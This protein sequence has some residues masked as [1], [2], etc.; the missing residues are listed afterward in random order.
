MLRQL[1]AFRK[2]HGY[3]RVDEHWKRYPELAGWIVAIRGQLETLTYDQIVSLND[4]G[5]FNRLDREWLAKYARLQ[6]FKDTMGHCDVPARW[7]KN[8]ALSVWVHN[9]RGKVQIVPWRRKLLSDLGFNFRLVDKSPPI[10][11]DDGIKRLKQYKER[12]GNCDV[13]ARWSEDK[14]LG[15]WLSRLRKRDVKRSLGDEK[16]RQLDNLGFAWNPFR[17]AW[18]LKLRELRAFKEQHGHCRVPGSPDGLGCWVSNIRHT[19]EKL[20]ETRIRRLNEIG[21]DWNPFQT[22]WS[23]QYKNILDYKQRFGHANVPAHWK[24]NPEL[25]RWVSEQR[26]KKAELS[27]DRIQLLEDAGIDWD[28]NETAWVRHYEELKE[29]RKEHGHCN[30]PMS[31]SLLRKWVDHQRAKADKMP[32][33]RKKLLDELGF[34]WTGYNQKVWMQRYEELK[35]YKVKHGHCSPPAR[36]SPLAKW[37]SV[38]RIMK[39]KMLTERRQLLDEIGFEWQILPHI[40]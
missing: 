18:E 38:Q 37:V 30:P 29:F 31:Q 13:P 35:D 32:K 19:K 22:Y 15:L 34:M 25:A 39:A 9:H 12:F 28:P 36:S 24:E 3:I 8:P 14:S 27:P 2:E 33:H 5:F 10:D 4:L 23:T 16:I 21:F 11:W 40:D 26:M 1:A 7:S 20:S 17:S 6:I